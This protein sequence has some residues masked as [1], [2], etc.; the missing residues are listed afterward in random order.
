V[1]TALDKLAL[2]LRTREPPSADVLDDLSVAWR[3]ACHEVGQTFHAWSAGEG[4]YDAVVAAI[5][6][7]ETAASILADYQA[8]FTSD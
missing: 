1:R 8:R 7:E 5:D 4:T 2:L 6:R 3:A